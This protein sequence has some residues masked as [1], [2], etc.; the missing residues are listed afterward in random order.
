MVNLELYRIFVTVAEDKNITKASEKLN[1]SQPAVTKHIQNLE[2]TLQVKLFMRS[3]KGIELTEEGKEIF[4]KARDCVETLN[5]IYYK[6]GKN[7]QLNL[8]VHA[9][10]L[11][12][13]FSNQISNF[14][15]LY[16]K[17]DINID[18]NITNEAINDMI[19]YL[20][21]GKLDVV[22][23]KKTDLYSKEKLDFICIGKLHDILITKKNS[24]YIDKTYSL[25][26]LKNEIIYTP[27][28]TSVTVYN[29]LKSIN[30][31]ENDLKL[32]HITYRTMIEIL[33]NVDGIGLATKEYIEDE[34]K[35]ERVR[36]LKIDFD[37]KPIEYG[38]YYKKDE[39]NKYVKKLISILADNK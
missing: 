11:N 35:N 37:I 31:N 3:N 10:M 7:I 4:E 34:L 32:K 6:F 23:S 16:N 29:F 22:I 14:Y 17:K 2:N 38:V 15:S 39:K 24:K 33:D 20:E 21:E 18:I 30:M 27:R 25:S 36:K 1:I 28:A 12:K 26:E 8:G 9:T 13:L 19:A 5:S